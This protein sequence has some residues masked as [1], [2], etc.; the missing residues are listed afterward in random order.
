MSCA[1][2]YDFLNFET[3]ISYLLSH[4]SKKNHHEIDQPSVFELITYL[5]SKNVNIV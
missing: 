4:I 2:S 3:F 5:S 1:G